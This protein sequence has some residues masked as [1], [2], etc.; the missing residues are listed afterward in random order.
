MPLNR[1]VTSNASALELEEV[2]KFYFERTK[3]TLRIED[4]KYLLERADELGIDKMNGGVE[5]L[6]STLKYKLEENPS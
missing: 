1:E 4:A 3:R 2:R 5:A 6:F